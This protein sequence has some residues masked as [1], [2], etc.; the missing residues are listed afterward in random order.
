MPHPC[1]VP[2][3]RGNYKNGPKVSVFSFPK[4]DALREKWIRAIKREH[5]SP[6]KH[7]KVCEKHFSEDLLTTT[8]AYDKET[9][10]L[11]E[12]E[13]KIKKLKPDAVPSLHP[14]LPKHFSTTAVSNRES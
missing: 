7:S 14:N 6:T 4:N 2:A 10:L 11:I 5:F 3:W 1:C 13:L 9:G 8:S 12:A